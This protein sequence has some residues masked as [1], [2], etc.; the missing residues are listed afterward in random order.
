MKN[1]LIE[2]AAG[3]G[4]PFRFGGKQRTELLGFPTAKADGCSE[5]EV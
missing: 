2:N 4:E 5:G 3:V 1:K